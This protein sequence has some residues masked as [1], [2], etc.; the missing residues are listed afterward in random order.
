MIKPKTKKELFE[1]ILNMWLEDE[2]DCI[3]EFCIHDR[4]EAIEEAKLEYEQ[5]LKMYDE[6]E[7]K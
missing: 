2:I 6:L 1:K 3:N 7:D 5:Y 4:K